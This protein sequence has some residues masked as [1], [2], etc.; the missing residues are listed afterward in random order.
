MIGNL[1]AGITFV[2]THIGMNT[3]NGSQNDIFLD[4]QSSNNVVEQN[5]ALNNAFDINNANGLP[6]NIN[7]NQFTSNTCLVSNPS[8]ICS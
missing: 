4:G 8:Y 5:Q 1:L 3:I 2:N 7:N 6:T